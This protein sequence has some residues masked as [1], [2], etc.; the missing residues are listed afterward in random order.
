MR[1]WNSA[2]TK[3]LWKAAVVLGAAAVVVAG[4]DVEHD[5]WNVDLWTLLRRW[6][7]EAGA[8]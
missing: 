7:V 4:S 6:I 3:T 8:M 5:D 1:Y 2:I